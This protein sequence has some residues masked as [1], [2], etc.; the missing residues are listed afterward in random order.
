MQGA[1]Q[2]VITSPEMCLK[3]PEFRKSLE[4]P[5]ISKRIAA[6]IIDEAHCITRWGDKFQDAYAS[7][8]TL[9]TFVPVR[10]PF[11]VTSATLTPE[12]LTTI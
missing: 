6:F 11:L 2:V 10:V 3:H 8:G 1:F 9:R 12:D 7:I 5:S 4:D